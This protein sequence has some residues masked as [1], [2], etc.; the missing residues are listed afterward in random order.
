MYPGQG[1]RCEEMSPFIGPKML[2]LPP[3]IS[4]GCI[5]SAAT[6]R[7]LLPLVFVFYLGRKYLFCRK[8]LSWDKIQNEY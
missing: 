1:D 3:T 8:S 6:Y 2:V 4:P 7:I 5:C